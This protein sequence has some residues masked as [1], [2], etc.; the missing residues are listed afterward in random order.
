MVGNK[1][2][3][4]LLIKRTIQRVH[5]NPN[6]ATK[7]LAVELAEESARLMGLEETPKKRLKFLQTLLQDYVVLTR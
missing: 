6:P 4:T 5:M 2:L 1:I 3:I 7:K